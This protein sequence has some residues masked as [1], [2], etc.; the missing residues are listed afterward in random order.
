MTLYYVTEQTD[1]FQLDL[2]FGA[3]LHWEWVK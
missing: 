2:K 3:L 1:I